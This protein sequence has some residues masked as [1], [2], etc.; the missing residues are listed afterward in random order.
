MQAKSRFQTAFY[1]VMHFAAS[2]FRFANLYGDHMVLQREISTGDRSFQSLVNVWGYIP[3][4]DNVTLTFSGNPG[5]NNAIV[6]CS[7]GAIL[8]Q[9][10]V[11]NYLALLPIIL[12]LQ[13]AAHGQPPCRHIWDQAV[14][15]RSTLAAQNMARSLSVMSCWEMSGFAVAR[16]TWCSLWHMSV[17][18]NTCCTKLLQLNFGMY[19]CMRCA[20]LQCFIRDSGSR[21]LLQHQTVHS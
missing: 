10:T 4:M 14:H 20:G 2:G 3:E 7:E 13:T 15:M 5:S 16:A 17:L 11:A 18:H 9:F 21:R 12:S 19:N 6:K 8:R 1:R